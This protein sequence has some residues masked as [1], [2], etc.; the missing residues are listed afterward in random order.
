M[1]QR[2]ER[3]EEP[4]LPRRLLIVDDSE[5][6]AILLLRS[7]S[8]SGFDAK[9]HI[10]GTKREFVRALDEGEPVDAILCDFNIPGFGALAALRVLEERNEDVPFIVM[11]GYVDEEEAV[12]V[13]RAGA[14]DFVSKTRLSRLA[15][16]LNREI[17]EARRRR[18]LAVAR[19]AV[20]RAERLSTLGYM[21]AG[22]AHDL[23]NILNPLSLQLQLLR[24]PDLSS[25][26]LNEVTANMAKTLKRGAQLF[27]RLRSLGMP[28]SGQLPSC[29]LDAEVAQAVELM[30][31]SIRSHRGVKL[32]CELDANG[33]VGLPAAE[34][35]SATVN[36][37]TNSLHAFAD[38]AGTIV[39]SSGR[40]TADGEAEH[41]FL[42][43]VDDGPGMNAEVRQRA[44]QR[45]FTTKQDGTGLGLSG[46]AAAVASCGGSLDIES[47]LGFGTCVR[48]RFPVRKGDS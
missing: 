36:L 26:S 20:E 5:D 35:V 39:V 27:E 13:L 3:P 21:A 18:E 46:I 16:A 1:S 11:S 6:D 9:G 37:V 44:T 43:V 10:V 7:L 40:S 38:Q 15:P 41:I 34:V 17:A 19:D 12:A 31:S 23:N 8:A 2:L 33:Q 24:R 30:G 29:D 28:Q 4:R 47:E 32:V 22:V 42:K 48:L 45:F 14:H 25:E